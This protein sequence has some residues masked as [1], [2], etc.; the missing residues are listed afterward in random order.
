MT[1]RKSRSFVRKH[2]GNI[3]QQGE[4]GGLT[5]LCVW[6]WIGPLPRLCNYG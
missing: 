3:A 2:N 4:G 5:E 6:L 1:F